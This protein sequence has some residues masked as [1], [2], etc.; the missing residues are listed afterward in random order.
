MG[1][2]YSP[3]LIGQNLSNVV[4]VGATD[5]ATNNFAWY[6]NWG[7]NTVHLCAPGSNILST[8]N[9]SRYGYLTGTS[10]ST[11]IVSGA[12]ALV[13]SILGQNS[14]NYYQAGQVG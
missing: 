12:A 7:Y 5:N 13:A 8:L 14:G 11:P 2:P 3:C 10:M 9:G 4:C 1:Y 6:S